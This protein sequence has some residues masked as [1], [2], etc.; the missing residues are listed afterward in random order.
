VAEGSL[1]ESGLSDALVIGNEVVTLWTPPRAVVFTSDGKRV[2]R[3]GPSPAGAFGMVD[4]SR[5]FAVAEWGAVSIAD[6]DAGHTA[7]DLTLVG[8]SGGQRGPVGAVASGGALVVSWGATLY[9][10]DPVAG[11]V[12]ATWPMPSCE[13][14]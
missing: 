4:G 9:V 8:D 12:T 11:A 2:P 6:G 13:G 10:I 3:E 14:R 7:R 5:W 1:G